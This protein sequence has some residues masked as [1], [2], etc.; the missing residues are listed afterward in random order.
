MH[1]NGCLAIVIIYLSM[2]FV[3]VRFCNQFSII[4]SFSQHTVAHWHEHSIIY[5]GIE[6]Q[7]SLAFFVSENSIRAPHL[8]TKA[9]Y[10]FTRHLFC[11]FIFLAYNTRW[12]CY[13]IDLT[14]QMEGAKLTTNS[15]FERIF[16][17]KNE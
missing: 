13:E 7:K 1:Q 14:S 8:Y 12:Y 15:I 9:F 17:I 4:C 3:T 11:S 6:R 16:A 10:S 2:T 5:M